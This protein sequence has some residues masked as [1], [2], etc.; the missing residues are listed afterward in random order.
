M[1]IKIPF[2]TTLLICYNSFAFPSWSFKS[3]ARLSVDQKSSAMSTNLR[4]RRPHAQDGGSPKM[5]EPEHEIK[6][7]KGC[8]VKVKSGERERAVCSIIPPF[9]YGTNPP[10]KNKFSIFRFWRLRCSERTPRVLMLSLKI[11]RWSSPQNP[12]PCLRCLNYS[13]HGKLAAKCTRDISIFTRHL[14]IR[15]TPRRAKRPTRLVRDHPSSI[16]LLG[17]P[18][19][20]LDTV[21]NHHLE[22]PATLP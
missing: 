19:S 12:F 6:K 11:L 18:V 21:N 13:V 1:D 16:H 10:G 9:T 17:T 4:H 14:R 3:Q 8:P 15:D 2:S 22:I 5:E 7:T 20:Y